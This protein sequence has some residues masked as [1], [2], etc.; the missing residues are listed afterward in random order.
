MRRIRGVVAAT[1]LIGGAA[2]SP[3]D[4]RSTYEVPPT[5]R[6]DDGLLENEDL[7]RV[8]S[9]A[10]R[11]DG[12]AL[13]TALTSD[14]P[15]VR[16]RAAFAMAS[17][18]DIGAAPE[19]RVLLSDEDPRVRADAAFAL[20]HYSGAADSGDQLVD[21]LERET[22]PV[23]RA[24]MIDA[25]GK[26]GYSRSLPVLLTLQGDDRAA[27][28]LALSRAVIRGAAPATTLDTLAVRATDPDPLIRRN[29]V[30]FVERTRDPMQWISVRRTLRNALDSLPD[31]DLAAMSIV[32]GIGRRFDVFTLPRI[33]DRARNAT[34][35]RVRV[36][37]LAALEGMGL[38]E[39]RLLT[40]LEG[41]ED[42]SHHVRETAAAT[43]AT[44]PPDPDVQAVLLT[45]AEEHPDDLVARAIVL[46]LLAQAGN[47]EPLLEWVRGLALDDGPGWSV[48]IPS[49]ARTGGAEPLDE[50]VRASGSTTLRVAR[51]A[52]ETL[53]QRIEETEEFAG[54]AATMALLE[55]AVAGANPEVLD[56]FERALAIRRGD[57]DPAEPPAADSAIVSED[58]V[59]DPNEE[60]IFEIDWAELGA[61]GARPQ[62]G[63]ETDVGTIVLELSADQ[64]P[65]TVQRIARLARDGRFDGVPFHRVVAN[66]VAQGGD[67]ARGSSPSPPAGPL[68]SE[69]TR[70]PFERG[71]IGM[72]NTGSLDTESTQ[73]FITHDRKPHLD[74]GYTSFGWVVDG[75][76]VV[77]RL[78]PYHRIV[79]T[80]M[81]EGS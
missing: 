66:F 74:G 35:W 77:D 78:Q 71:V 28:T 80:W 8:A 76:D 43:L 72:A 17:L 57:V 31:D 33:I 45:W 81:R 4:A 22:D 79:S 60:A 49:L 50:L 1:L 40:L 5:S 24:A 6:A 48:A 46:T 30:Y 2:C 58:D 3:P 63:F 62:L 11:R 52:A 55:R 34:D 70:I 21:L 54:P 73:F 20:A 10:A 32:A 67:L 25:L 41:L 26:A 61:L 19:L 12:A 75:M 16:A 15:L 29:A 14:D 18:R 44:S 56:G 27:A 59:V 68:R 36:N 7:Q 51:E 39:D 69:I 47:P 42:P 38:G 64:A 13:R 65:L 53:L 23:V 9:A 37:A